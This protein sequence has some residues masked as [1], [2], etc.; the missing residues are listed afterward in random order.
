MNT[1]NMSTKRIA[2]NAELNNLRTILGLKYGVD[3]SDPKNASTLRYGKI[4][5]AT[6]ADV[7]GFHIRGLVL[8]ALIDQ[9]PTLSAIPG[10]F[11]FFVTPILKATWKGQKLN[12]FRVEDFEAWKKDRAGFS[13]KYY[14]GLGTSSAAE[15]KEYFSQLGSFVKP[16][17]FDENSGTAL[18]IAF[19]ND[20]NARKAW[21]SNVSRNEDDAGD[22]SSFVYGDLRDYSLYNIE[23][24]IPDVI[25]G[26]KPSQRKV[27]YT[28]LRKKIMRE[29]KVSQLAGI[30]SEFS[31]YHHGEN[32]LVDTIISMAQS[33]CGSNN[34]N[35][36][37]PVGQFGSRLMNGN[38]SASGRYIFTFL[39]EI[40]RHIFREDDD[41]ILEYRNDD[42]SD[43]EPVVYVPVLPMV[44]VNGCSGIATGWSTNVPPHKPD[45]VR[46]LCLDILSGN[47]PTKLVPHYK[48]FSGSIT[49]RGDDD[50]GVFVCRGVHT[51]ARNGDD[52]I[53]RVTEIPIGTSIEKY[54]DFLV[55][56]EN[57]GKIK[58]FSNNSNDTD[59]DFTVEIPG[60]VQP[61]EI[62]RELCL[63]STISTNN[64][65]LLVDGNVV[66]FD[67][68]ESIARHFCDRRLVYYQ[69]RIQSIL[70]SVGERIAE[71]M[72]KI[73]FINSICDGTLE[74]SGVP[75]EEARA[76]IIA[77]DLIEPDTLLSIP[78]KNLTLERVQKLQ[79]DLEAAEIKQREY[80]DTSPTVLF[81]RE[82]ESLEI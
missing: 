70:G 69:M 54:K 42:G 72:N 41:S 17:S 48:G 29:I 75:I 19:G 65:H 7:D 52:W 39:S 31:S 61:G 24:S 33:H 34:L 67:T 30:V 28:C 74:I 56:A 55:H 22:V 49:P 12:F 20:T 14:K 78:I 13:V 4:I 10:F 27:L 18:E 1:K 62:E 57:T 45:D 23:R 2:D 59:I 68:V 36:L 35:L 16:V 60:S 63:T 82:L 77:L 8:N 46:R 21:I 81:T 47:P 79:S 15:A 11:S 25:D 58:T 73:K 76:R 9:Y 43:V 6:D 50:D 3:Y 51:V 26:L 44:L 38:D 37:E 80:L 53:V 32:S 40:T 64:M 66:K 71:L 5:I